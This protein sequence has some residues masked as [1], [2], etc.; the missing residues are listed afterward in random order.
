MYRSTATAPH[1]RGMTVLE[2][3]LVII[4]IVIVAAIL[5][6]V[7]VPSRNPSHRISCLSNEKQLGLAM[8]QYV[9]DYDSKLPPRQMTAS[10]KPVSWRSSVYPYLKSRSL[11]QCPSDSFAKLPD[12]ERDGLT[13]S[14]AV[15]GTLGG[16]FGDDHPQLNTSKL[17]SPAT[18]ILLCESTSSFGDFDPLKPGLFALQAQD[19]RDGGCMQMHASLSNFL[20]ADGHAKAINPLLTIGAVDQQPR[21]YWTIDNHPFDVNDLKTAQYTL[22]YAIEHGPKN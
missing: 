21:N 5:F 11:F 22:G 7:F 2:V 10:G 15:D 9:Q 20:F 6:P 16:S 18:V 3:A 14:Y 12:F 8:L 19:G 17:K 1:Q 4:V 13:R